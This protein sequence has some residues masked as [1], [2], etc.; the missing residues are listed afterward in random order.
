MLI[1]ERSVALDG[2]KIRSS[3]LNFI[4]FNWDFLCLMWKGEQLLIQI[5]GKMDLYKFEGSAL[6]NFY[7]NGKES[8]ATI[9]SLLI[10]PLSHSSLNWVTLAFTSLRA[11]LTIQSIW[12][13]KVINRK[14]DRSVH[15]TLLWKGNFV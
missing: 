12:P 4:N 1:W 13:W 5:I 2:T 10:H 6:A 9:L 7:V 11:L 8:K 15:I 3:L 14:S